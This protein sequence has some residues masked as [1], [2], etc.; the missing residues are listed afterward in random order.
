MSPSKRWTL[1]AAVVGS[2]VVFLDATVVNVALP[3]IG[4]DLRSAFLGVLEGQTYVYSG[5]LLSL[6]ALLILAGALSDFHGRRRVF[7]IGLV[8]FALTSALCGLAPTLEL[9]VVFRLFQGAAG[10]LLV[11]GSLSIL[12][13]AFSGEE[14]GRV[15]GIWAGA[16]AAVA[17][18]G[19]YV[20][21]Q[22]VEA[23]SWRVI[24]LVNV[25]VVAIAAWAT[26]VGVHESRDETST[27]RF[28]WLGAAVLAVAVGGLSFGAV[29]GQQRDWQA[30]LAFVALAVGALAAVAF[31]FLMA[32]QREPLVPLEMFRSRNFSVTNLSTLLIYGALYLFGYYLPIFTQGVLSY[33]AAA[34]GAALV[35]G[36]LFLVLFSTISGS[37]AGRYGPQRFMVIGPALMALGVLWFARIPPDSPPLR[38]D[39]GAGVEWLLA[40][41][42]GLLI[43]RLALVRA[44]ALR[45][46]GLVAGGAIA[47]AGL[48]GV[49]VSP[50][51]AGYGRDLLPGQLV[52]GIGTTIMVAPLTTALMASVP[53]ARSG[54]ASAINNAVSRVGPQLAGAVIFVAITA[55]FYDSLAT[56]VPGLDMT[57]PA[58]RATFPPLNRPVGEVSTDVLRAALQASTGGFHLAMVIAAGLLV[59]GAL[60]NLVGIRDPRPEERAAAAR[61]VALAPRPER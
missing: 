28:D 12:T 1:V 20:G 4:R 24:F 45:A 26:V 37:L 52:Y 2:A 15:F 22:L 21:G 17:L 50:G 35:P 59:A 13:A 29:Y 34:A 58:V 60:V 40:A 3:A 41:A 8:G 9:L 23:L 16:S 54:L 51:T 18:I 61:G 38:L 25:P 49:L 14:R 30:P 27:G 19:P 43:A 36:F 57:S 44:G 31:P 47:L 6:S 48:G 56:L 32:R 10:A 39:P 53:V 42:M 5:Y 46:A 7:L 11:P 33:S 55:T